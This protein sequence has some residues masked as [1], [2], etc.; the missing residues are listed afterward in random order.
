MA[1]DQEFSGR[2]QS[3]ALTDRGGRR[4]HNEDAVLARPEAG[5]W[6]V[7]DG[8]GGHE[9]GD[10]A[11][12]MLVEAL[13]ELMPAATLVDAIDQLDD[14][15]EAV[16]DRIRDHSSTRF[17]GRTMGCTMVTMLASGN[18]GACLWA[19][20]SRLYRWRDG[21]LNALSTDH[22]EVQNLVEQGVLSQ[23]EAD[24]HPNANVITRAVGAAP[25]LHVDVALFSIRPGD[26]FL[27]CSDGLYNEVAP[28]E[29]A[30]ELPAGDA[31]QVAGALMGRALERGARDNV[32]VIVAVREGVDE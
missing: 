16:N 31:G 26:R 2:W 27:L 12:E 5:L 24:N 3:A 14:A 1:V 21:E 30:T 17:G 9:A 23:E 13:A 28:A 20:D 29:I 6:C 10:L 11:S 19:G 4:K 18:L 7:A 22:S 8:M 32:S 15:M 25:V